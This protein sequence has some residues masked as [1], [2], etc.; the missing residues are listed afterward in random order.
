MA[1]MPALIFSFDGF[2]FPSVTFKYM[3]KP[4]R[5]PFAVVIG[6]MIVAL[7]YV[8]VFTGILVGANGGG[9]YQNINLPDNCR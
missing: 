2:Y 7:V 5:G 4:E 6:V 3:K 9:S 1:S 8:L